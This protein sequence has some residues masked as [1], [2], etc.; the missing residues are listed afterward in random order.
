MNFLIYLDLLYILLPWPHFLSSL[1]YPLPPSS[2]SSNCILTMVSILLFL[3]SSSFN[4]I[5]SAISLLSYVCYNYWPNCSNL[6]F[7]VELASLILT[8]WS[9][10]VSPSNSFSCYVKSESEFNFINFF[11]FLFLLLFYPACCGSTGAN[12]DMSIRSLSLRSWRLRKLFRCSR[13]WRMM[14]L[15]TSFFCSWTAYLIWFWL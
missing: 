3:F 10:W 13:F 12:W 4:C 11:L 2:S 7:V 6:L 14:S 9:L 8:W 5:N 15:K 1:L